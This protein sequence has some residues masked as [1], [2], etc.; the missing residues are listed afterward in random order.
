MRRNIVAGNWKMNLNYSEAFDLINQL[1]S[2]EKALNTKLIVAPPSLYLGAFKDSQH[3]LSLSAQNVHTEFNGAFTGEISSTMLN[4]LSIPYCIVGHSERRTLFHETDD[5]IFDKV[6]SLLS[7]EVSPI[8][9]CGESKEEREQ[10]DAYKVITHQLNLLLSNLDAEQIQQTIIAYEPVWA[11][12]TGLTA[13]P[14][15]AQLMH[16]HIRKEIANHFDVSVSENISLLY[17]GS[18]K[19]EN[20]AALFSKEDIDGGL[21]GGASLDFSSFISIAKSFS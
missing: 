17:G 12:G 6:K 8:F 1:N 13:S 10:G 9:C 18:C 16:H 11:I 15:D 3:I 4:S 2:Y 7:Y 14:E 5:L 19:P 21:I 20:A